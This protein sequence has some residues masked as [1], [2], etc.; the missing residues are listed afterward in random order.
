M[1]PDGTGNPG[2]QGRPLSTPEDDDDETG[3]APD[4][5]YKRISVHGMATN[6]ALDAN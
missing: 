5:E 4:L 2:R 1:P 6:Q 3:E